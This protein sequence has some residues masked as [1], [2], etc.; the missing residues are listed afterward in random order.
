VLLIFHQHAITNLHNTVPLTLLLPVV[1]T[2][3]LI[4]RPALTLLLG[5]VP[6]IADQS[7]HNDQANDIQCH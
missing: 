4:V 6:A 3:A 5:S 2:F 1:L 7:Q